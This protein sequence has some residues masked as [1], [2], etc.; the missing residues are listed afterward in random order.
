MS[1]RIR[2]NIAVLFPEPVGPRQIVC[3]SESLGE[4]LSRFGFI[5]SMLTAKLRSVFGLVGFLYQSGGKVSFGCRPGVPGSSSSPAGSQRRL[6]SSLAESCKGKRQGTWAELRS[7]DFIFSVCIL[8]PADSNTL[9]ALMT[10][11]RRALLFSPVMPIRIT[12]WKICCSDFSL[13]VLR[14]SAEA[15]CT[16]PSIICNQ[17]AVGSLRSDGTGEGLYAR[18]KIICT[19]ICV[20][21][22][23][24]V[25]AASPARITASVM[26]VLRESVGWLIL[27]C[28]AAVI[29]A[30]FSAPASWNWML[31]CALIASSIFLMYLAAA[32]VR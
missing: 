16:F 15:F 7:C 5:V 27:S 30:R 26:S 17:V 14:L 32:P 1:A 31:P 18:P 20:P 10:L 28:R 23:C 4:I 21:S 22:L 9:N 13:T 19:T 12:A 29:A 25:N 6:A 11:C 24:S 8:T 2:C 3:S